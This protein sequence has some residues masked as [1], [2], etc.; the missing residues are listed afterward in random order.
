M[1]LSKA[2]K[3]V[4][5]INCN[6]IFLYTLLMLVLWRWQVLTAHFNAASH[7]GHTNFV[8]PWASCPTDWQA[9]LCKAIPVHA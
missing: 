8:S 5:E 4:L 7:D 2:V 1:V 6:D 3:L 9:G